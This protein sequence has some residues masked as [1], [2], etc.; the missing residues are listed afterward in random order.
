[1]EQSDL[2]ILHALLD[3]IRQIFTMTRFENAYVDNLGKQVGAN[4]DSTNSLVAD[5]ALFCPSYPWA[6]GGLR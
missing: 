4:G 1:M 5:I 3:Q 6:V 2:A